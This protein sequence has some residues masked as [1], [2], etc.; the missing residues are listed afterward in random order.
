MNF[1]TWCVDVAIAYAAGILLGAPMGLAAFWLT[2]SDRA[3]GGIIL[4]TMVGLLIGRR[5]WRRGLR[6]SRPG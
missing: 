5:A 3:L 2:G 1:R 6:P 4:L